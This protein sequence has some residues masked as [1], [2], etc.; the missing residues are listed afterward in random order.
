MAF[1]RWR[2]LKTTDEQGQSLFKLFQAFSQGMNDWWLNSGIVRMEETPES[3]V[4]HGVSGSVYEV[5][6]TDEGDSPAIEVF[7]AQAQRGFLQT[8]MVGAKVEISSVAEY[9]ESGKT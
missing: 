6:K 1:C 8:G 5:L 2:F 3:Y 4:V 7:L 9:R